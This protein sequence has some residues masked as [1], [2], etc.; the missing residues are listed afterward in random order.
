MLGE[1]QAGF[2]EGYSTNDHI[3]TLSSLI[4]LYLH[5]QKRLY[6][7]FIDY[8]KA[9]DLVDRAS[10]WSKLLSSGINGKIL[11]V[12]YNMY[13]QA[14]SCVKKDKTLSNL[15]SCLIGV[16]QG[17]NL[18]PLL[19]AIY[20][21][22]FEL[23]LSRKYK[24][25][26]TVAD[27]L[28]IH[29]SDDDV[30]VFFRLYVLLYADDT[31][32]MAE[33]PGDLQV[34]LDAAYDYCRMWQLTVNTSKTKVVVFSRGKIRKYPQFLYGG[35]PL[36]VVSEYTYL[37]VVLNYNGLFNKAVAKQVNQARRAMYSLVLKAHKLQLPIDIQCELFNQLVLP[38][39]LYGSEI[40]GYSKLDH[41][42][43]FHRKFI[44][45]ILKLNKGTPNCMVYGEVGQFNI[46]YIIYQRMISYWLRIINGKQSKLSCMLLRLMYSMYN[47]DIY[48]F[49]WLTKIKYILDYCG[50][51][52]MFQDV[53]NANTKWLKLSLERKLKD[54]CIQN[55]SSDVFNNSLCTNYRIF[56]TE[57]GTE[58]YL[59]I[60]D[61][62][63]RIYLSKFRCGNHYLPISKTRYAAQ[64][65]NLCTLCNT[66]DIGDEYH[67]ILICS[68]F[69]KERSEYIK[70]YYYNKPNVL[71]FSVLFNSRD[72]KEIY[73]LAKFVKHIMTTFSK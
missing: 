42:E 51:S 3:F 4:E 53:F 6:C 16:R 45:H 41:I 49:K 5:R 10:L 24:G 69:T 48:Q 30:E 73:N 72:V 23:F 36:E 66:Q 25:L 39:L 9:F 64:N 59:R 21:N 67:Y 56:K 52:N 26:G 20:L 58:V 65:S 8:K 46:K 18:S 60:L 14:K 44:K 33:S 19:F 62:N 29:L 38:I 57:P 28:R 12:I 13:D 70:K 7:A 47:K 55:W 61:T 40:W 68:H 54:I 34:A 35:N 71:K 63:N 32:I 17:E 15:F 31:I 22:D 43:T 27:D 50:Y 37:G 2:R 11:R 1:E